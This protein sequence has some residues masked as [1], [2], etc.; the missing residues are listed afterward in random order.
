MAQLSYKDHL[1][2]QFQYTFPFGRLMIFK[3]H[4]FGRSKNIIKCILK[5]FYINNKLK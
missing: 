2:V 4:Q 5:F 3:K 1:L